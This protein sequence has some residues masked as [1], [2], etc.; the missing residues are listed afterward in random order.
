M[1]QQEQIQQHRLDII[2][3]LPLDD[4]YEPV[5]GLPIPIGQKLI[6]KPIIQ[7]EIKLSS[8][9]M[10]TA[11]SS[12]KK[13]YMGIVMLMGEGVNIP[14]REGLKVEYEEFAHNPQSE[15][16]Y[17]GEVYIVM[18]QHNIRAV[19]PPDSFKYPVWEGTEEKRRIARADDQKSYRKKVDEKLDKIQNE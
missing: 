2:K 11:S 9:L 4:T 8:G 18:E 3:S 17:R 7:K 5:K 14:V 10:L 13:Q 19:M 1:T 15:L 6:I 16:V 12:R